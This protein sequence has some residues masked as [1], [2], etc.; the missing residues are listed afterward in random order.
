MLLIENRCDVK[1][2]NK[3]NFTGLD[4][5]ENDKDFKN[6]FESWTKLVCKKK[7]LF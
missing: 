1:L 3:K 5:I 4:L 7:F 2:K 6:H